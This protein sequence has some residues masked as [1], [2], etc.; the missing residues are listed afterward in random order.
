MASPCSVMVAAPPIRR[1][2]KG[3]AYVLAYAMARRQQGEPPGDESIIGWL[4]NRPH[5]L[6]WAVSN[7]PAECLALGLLERP[8]PRVILDLRHTTLPLDHR[9]EQA[10]KTCLQLSGVAREELE[11]GLADRP[12]VLQVALQLLEAS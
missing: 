6:A 10:L 4:R 8:L 7:R 12:H 11:L 9:S 1:R 5:R 3:P 2:P